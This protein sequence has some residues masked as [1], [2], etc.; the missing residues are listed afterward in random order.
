MLLR[1]NTN[2]KNQ[3]KKSLS[4]LITTILLII[5]TFALI[6]IILSWGKNFT[7]GSLSQTD[8]IASY[9]P[10]D[11]G[12]FVTINKGLNGRFIVDY[13]PPTGTG[14]G[15]LNIV[16]YSLNTYPQ[17]PL[18]PPVVIS[19]NSSQALDLGIVDTNKFTVV[20]YLSDNTLITKNNIE[21]LNKSPS[22][23][24]DGFISVP[25][26]FLYNTTNES[27]MGFCVSKYEMKVDQTGDGVGDAN[28]SCEYSTYQTWDNTASGCAYNYGTNKLVSTPQ[29]Y[30]LVEISQIDSEAACESL[31]SG[32]HLITNEERMTIVRNLE[33]VPSNWS[34]NKI[35]SGYLY[36]GHND[37]SPYNAL[38]ASTDD[39][40]GYYLT[41]NTTG[42]QRRTYKLTNGQTLWDFS[43]NVWEWA[44]KNFPR[45]DEPN[46]VYDV[47]GADYI[48]WNWFEFSKG[49]SYARYLTNTG[50]LKYKDL[51]SINK[52]YNTNQGI[53]RIYT[54][55][56]PNDTST[57]VYGL[58]SGGSWYHG[59]NAGPLAL[60]LTTSP[61]NRY[62]NFGLRCA[63]VP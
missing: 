37:G 22:N 32:Y 8:N 33:R 19:P 35:G 12:M 57:S 55:S 30:P 3:T 18:D 24:P 45:K 48:G 36:S 29:G 4:P 42:N 62:S 17:V 60:G 31:G 40:N 46:G 34:G 11:A 13:N 7:L 51:Y 6:G 9:K 43:G 27:A 54:Y 38:A 23:C 41:G 14:L 20:L 58:F 56:D 47:N 28:T 59:S 10:S 52:N 44:D 49:T 15:D 50:G 25:G 2:C 53:G 39:S 26:S 63:V 21:T 61:S 16:G 5:V 1:K